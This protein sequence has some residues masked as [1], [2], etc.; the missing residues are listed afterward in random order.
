[1][2]LIPVILALAGPTVAAV[3]SQKPSAQTPSLEPEQGAQTPSSELES[4]LPPSEAGSAQTPSI[5]LDGSVNWLARYA[6]GDGRGLSV[7]NY[8]KGFTFSQSITLNTDIKVPVDQID[9]TLALLADL[10]TSQPGFL[11]SVGL[12]LNGD[13]WSAEYGDFPMG[14][15]GSP[16]AASG[17]TLTG[18]K[19]TWKASDVLSVQGTVAQVSGVKQTKTFRGNTAQETVRFAFHPPDRPLQNVP[20]TRNLNGLQYFPLGTDY[21]E[22]FTT[23]ELAFATDGS[24]LSS[25]LENYGLGFL[26]ETIQN[27]PARKLDSGGYAVVFTGEEYFL[28]LKRKYLALIR[29]RLRTYID[30]YNTE[31]GLTGDEAES[32]PLTE[33]TQY[34][35][36]FLKAL[37]DSV[38]IEVDSQTFALEDAQRQRFYALGRTKVKADSVS[39]KVKRDEEFVAIDDPEL[40]EFS[41]E[42]Y[43]EPGVI[44]LEAPDAFFENEDHAVKATFRYRAES[45]A[46][47]LGLSVLPGSEAVFLNGEQLTKGQDYFMQYEEGVLVLQRQLDP[48][49]KLRIEYE[50]ARGGLFGASNYSR[51]FQGTTLQY[52][53]SEDLSL[54]VDLF[55]V[56]DTLQGDVNPE[57]IATM[58]NT[59]WVAGVSGQW[60]ANGYTANV[61]LGAALNRFPPDDNQKE[62]LPNRV[63]AIR[64]LSVGGRELV[65]VG[66]RDGLTVYDGLNWSSYSATQGLLAGPTVH[67][68]A[69]A[70]G[71]A[72]IATSGGVSVVDLASGTPSASFARRSNWT[73][74][75]ALEGLPSSTAYAVQVT[76]NVVWVG[77]NRGLATAPLSKITDPQAWTAYR[78]ADD[79]GLPSDR[80]AHLAT[81]G[82]TLYV[83]TDQG[84]V[85]YRATAETFEPVPGLSATTIHDLAAADN[86]LYV[87]TDTGVRTISDGRGVG[88]P[89]FG[90]AVQT[91]DVRN[92]TL[93][94]GTKGGLFSGD[95]QRIEPAR[96]RSITA[97]GHTSETVWA[98]ERADEAFDLRLYRVGGPEL[99]VDVLK[100]PTT[101]L[102]G[103]TENRYRPVPASKHTETGWQ[104][105]ASI[106]KAFGPL[107]LSGR[108]QSV[109]PGFSPVGAFQNSDRHSIRLGADY[110]ISENVSLSAFHEEGLLGL[111]DAPYQRIRDGLGVSIETDNGPT[112]SLDSTLKRIDRRSETPGFDERETVYKASASQSLWDDQVTLQVA[113]NRTGTENLA[114]PDRSKVKSRISTN[115]TVKA[116]Y[117]ID[118]NVG[119]E[120]PL[121]W[122]FGR[123]SGER[124]LNWG[125][126][127]S[128]SVSLGRLPLSLQANYSGSGQLPARGAQRV[129]LDQ[130]ASLEAQGATL[131]LGSGTVTPSASVS[132]N[133]VDLLG[134]N[135]RLKINGQGTVR[136]NLGNVESR[137]NY[138]RQQT[139][140]AYSNLTRT[141]DTANVSLSY[142]G[143]P[144]LEPTLRF[145]G[146]LDTFSHPIFG[147]ITNVNYEVATEAA[148]KP[149]GPWSANLSLSRSA[150]SADREGTQLVTYAFTQRI[151]YQLMPEL[152]PSLRL[153]AKYRQ[154]TE[155]NRKVNELRSEINLEAQ[156]TPIP[157]WSATVTGTYLFGVDA[158]QAG[159]DYNSF[160]ISVD[161]GRDFSF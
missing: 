86:T 10:D 74:V 124:T 14:R 21:V 133:V 88:W 29:D 134:D 73:T 80:I 71:R 99:S 159:Q 53:P 31:Q 61:S 34:E 113:Y 100:A 8:S 153:N 22:G 57:T 48:D 152:K 102:D 46:Y 1:M 12:A 25:V 126:S 112:I 148:W 64:S 137:L 109:S 4:P 47:V 35:Q 114:N 40:A 118:V 60:Q 30:D 79:N 125:A 111:F 33:G 160:A 143:I 119:Y 76:N 16:F 51:S 139:F 123:V 28:V 43:G 67:D 117:G 19:G 54:N 89:V 85:R 157:G 84:L 6:L 138:E 39:V 107:T 13:R 128:N 95:G 77:T 36:T 104:G 23:I 150:R 96:G 155:R 83:G 131:S 56:A 92:G 11:Q 41:T 101:G 72:L 18:V 94:Y 93:W 108:L 78:A 45:Q 149:G 38:R 151:S 3:T 116:P 15:K 130:N 90:K 154:G 75:G 135:R 103:R 98:G 59:H 156:V 121:T 65:L 81:A 105:R 66:H 145:S 147:Q 136:G 49:D 120:Q 9:A 55:R 42:V 62:N 37:S 69:S 91:V 68:I 82:G 27:D 161:F 97:I 115:A 20:Y 5:Q 146:N 142:L 7:K 44:G 122:S 144:N 2:P 106:S 127:W 63:K 132:V 24:G 50:T 110:A 158:A 141:S 17:R 70:P 52:T 87:A 32:Y 26:T 140:Q 129:T 58:P